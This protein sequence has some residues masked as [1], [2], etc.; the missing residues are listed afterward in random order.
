LLQ[1]NWDAIAKIS[2]FKNPAVAKKRYEQIR[3]KYRDQGADTTTTASPSKAHDK[4]E[5]VTPKKSPRK[6]L[7]RDTPSPSRLK[8]S[9]RKRIKVE[10]GSKIKPEPDLVDEE[11]DEELNLSDASGWD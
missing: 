6:G 3:A 4:S 2:G 1:F 8:G 10:I 7:K 5:P 9:S 11:K